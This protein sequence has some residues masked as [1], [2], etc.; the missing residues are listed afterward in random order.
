MVNG[1]GKGK[2]ADLD[3]GAHGK[4]VMG[5]GG[6]YMPKSRETTATNP[7]CNPKSN[8]FRHGYAQDLKR[9][10]DASMLQA[11]PYLGLPRG[12]CAHLSGTKIRY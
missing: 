4:K 7:S 12:P 2:G 1:E 5:S 3:R 10:L 8:V 6:P 9:E 11:R